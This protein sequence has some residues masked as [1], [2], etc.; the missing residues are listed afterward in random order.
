MIEG[1]TESINVTADIGMQP[2]TPI[3]LQGGVQG[4]AASLNNGDGHFIRNE[5]FNQKK[6]YKFEQAIGIDF[7]IGWFH[8]AVHKRRS[9]A[10][11]VSK[12][13]GQLIGPTEH[14]LFT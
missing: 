6:V 13:I 1:A 10:M 14:I 8:I 11:Q 3:L 12:R 4:S 9:L 2:I 5:R 7:L